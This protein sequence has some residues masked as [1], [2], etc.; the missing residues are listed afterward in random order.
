MEDKSNELKIELYP[1]R[2]PRYSFDKDSLKKIIPKDALAYSFDK[3]KKLEYIK[4]NTHVLNR[5]YTANNNHYTI[6]IKKDDI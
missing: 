6:R 2:E 5:F 3:D 4:E 1:D